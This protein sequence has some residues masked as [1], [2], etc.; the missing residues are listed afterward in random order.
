MTLLLIDLDNTLVD[1]SSAFLRW[2]SR[3][4]ESLGSPEA[5]LEWLVGADADGYRPRED[6]ASRIAEHFGLS[7]TR[8][9]VL[10]AELRAGFVE[11]MSLDPEVPLALGAARAAGWLLVVVTNGTV[12]QQERKIRHL[13]L[14]EHL[15]GWTIS[16][17]AGCKKPDARIFR[18]AAEVAGR[19][20]TGA[21]MVGD[22]PAA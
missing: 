4:V 17:A 13:G 2:A 14:D 12:A 10:L 19:P 5:E 20:L 16:E 11:E 21:W 9:D 15:D 1:R 6:L 7:V 18:R 22:H 3:F 8:R